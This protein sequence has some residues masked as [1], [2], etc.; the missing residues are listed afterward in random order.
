MAIGLIWYF[1]YSR[2]HSRQA[3]R[4]SVGEAAQEV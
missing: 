3:R 1:A 2:T 4:E